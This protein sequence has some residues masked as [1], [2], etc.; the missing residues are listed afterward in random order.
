MVSLC[1]LLF[2]K[3]F[4]SSVYVPILEETGFPDMNQTAFQKGISCADAIFSTQEVLLN[5]VCQGNS[6]F[7]YLYDIEKE[8]NSPILLSHLYSAG[9]NGKM[10]RLVKSWYQSPTSCVKH[11]DHSSTPFQTSRGVKQGSVLSPSLFLI[12]MNTLLERMRNSNCG[13]SLQGYFIGT[14]VHADDVC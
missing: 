11:N 5:Y 12:V 6:P 2:L 14:A 3:L 10:W 1:L 7:L 4:F 9:I 8:F 13:G